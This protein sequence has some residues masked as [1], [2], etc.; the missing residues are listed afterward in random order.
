MLRAS[1]VLLRSSTKI[2]PV[3]IGSRVN[4]SSSYS[5]SLKFSVRSYASSSSGRDPF[6]VLGLQR[7]CSEN[8]LREAYLFLSRSYHPDNP[9]NKDEPEKYQALFVEVQEA[10][11]QLLK[12][13]TMMGKDF[14]TG[15]ESAI[16]YDN[17]TDQKIEYHFKTAPLSVRDEEL[18]Y[19][20]VEVT[21][22]EYM[23]AFSKL[24]VKLAAGLIALLFLAEVANPQ[25]T[26]HKMHRLYIW[27]GMKPEDRIQHQIIKD[28]PYRKF[29]VQQM[30]QMA[31]N[32]LTDEVSSALDQ[33]QAEMD[34][35]QME[36]EM[37]ALMNQFK[38]GNVRRV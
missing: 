23:V 7:N 16:F 36:K 25:W 1:R 27:L 28:D 38:G 13:K 17:Y 14:G 34:D 2:L 5:P 19:E 3:R 20:D 22:A 31:R 11:Q 26:E 12:N 30:H 32:E 4:L 29:N 8:E 35:E 18:G 24:A 15:S 37:E 33:R 21:P 10:Y 9:K 6:E